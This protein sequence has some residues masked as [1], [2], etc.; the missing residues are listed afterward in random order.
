[1]LSMKVLAAANDAAQKYGLPGAHVAAVIEVESAGKVA[2]PP[3]I[4]F[5]PH[6]F[7]RLLSES[8]R[9]IAVQRG[10]ASEK[11]NKSLYPKTQTDRWNQFHLAAEIDK[12]AAIEATSFGVGQV[13][14]QNW[15]SLG[16]ASASDFFDHVTV[17]LD[18]QIDVMMR[19]IMVNKLDD[20]L[21]DGRWAAFARG[22]N[23][24]AYAKNKYDTKLAEAAARYGGVVSSRDGMLRLG[25]KGRR[26]RELQALLSR[27]GH[28]VRVDGDFG[29]STRDALMAFQSSRAITVDGVYGPQTERALAEF[30]Q[31]DTDK[32]GSVKVTEIN[33]VKQ[34]AGGVAGGLVVEGLQQRVD[35]ATEKLQSISGFDPWIGYGL[36]AL[37]IVALGLGAWGVWRMVSGWMDSRKT[38]ET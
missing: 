24:P 22:Y 1:M 26:V 2:T 32:P 10:L 14:G 17:G 6:V 29:P 12:S 13:L 15:K 34:G 7:Y 11:W 37:S 33:E 31:G 18:Q 8:M 5:E 21:R 35:D 30:R 4:L 23:G 38:V 36:A 28:P 27:A 16:F 19:Y 3:V 9:A 25:A 20:E